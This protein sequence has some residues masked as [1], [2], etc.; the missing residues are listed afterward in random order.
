MRPLF[1]LP[2]LVLSLCAQAP[3][4]E[5]VQTTHRLRLDGLRQV[6]G[7]L[8]LEKHP[9]KPY[10]EALVAYG[11]VAQTMDQDPKG[12]EALLDRVL[13]GLSP[14]K[15]AESLALQASLLGLKIRFKP[16]EA[17]ILAPHALELFGQA[18]ASA[19]GSPRVWLLQGIHVLYTPEPFGG[20]AQAALPLLQGAVKAAE[21]EAVPADAWVPHWGKAESYAWL[22]TA[23]AELGLMKEANAHLDQALALDPNYGYAKVVVAAMLG[24]VA[25]Q[26]AAK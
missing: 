14:R 6:Q 18:R 3:L 11:I 12:A 21:A 20:G 9:A 5:R 15:D 4:A 22:A 26:G 23:E 17:M 10:Y 16:G 24:R 25:K 19:P 8:A 1:L 7:E 13:A 2:F